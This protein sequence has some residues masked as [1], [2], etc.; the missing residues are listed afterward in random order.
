KARSAKQ[1]RVGCD[2]GRVGPEMRMDMGQPQR[3][4]A[5]GNT[6]AFGQIDDLSRQAGFPGPRPPPCQPQC[7]GKLARL[8]AALPEQIAKKLAPP[9]LKY[10]FGPGIFS[11]IG[12]IG[13]RTLIPAHGKAVDVKTQSPER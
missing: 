6:G 5:G 1:P 11:Q 2:P 12:G 9:G 4:G 13:Q 7:R 10:A 3:A 8:S